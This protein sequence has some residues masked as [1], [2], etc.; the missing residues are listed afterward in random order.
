MARRV[1]TVTRFPV[2]RVRCN[3]ATEPDT[4]RVLY[5]RREDININNTGISESNLRRR[6]PTDRIRIG[7]PGVVRSTRSLHGRRALSRTAVSLF[8]AHAL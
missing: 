1:A 2:G 3:D 6:R 7:D 4:R 8:L 5:P